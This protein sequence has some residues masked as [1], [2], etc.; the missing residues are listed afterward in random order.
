[1]AQD[2]GVLVPLVFLEQL[3]DLFVVPFHGVGKEVTDLALAV[4]GLVQIN[5]NAHFNNSNNLKIVF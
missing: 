4:S 1:V 2:I 5:R 3:V